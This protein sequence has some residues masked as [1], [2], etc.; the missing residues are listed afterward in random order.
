MDGAFPLAVHGPAGLLLARDAVG[1]RT[2]C[3]APKARGGF[4]YASDIKTLLTRSG[5]SGNYAAVAIVA[6]CLLALFRVFKGFERGSRSDGPGQ[7]V[8][9]AAKPG[10]DDPSVS[11]D[12]A[13][14][15]IHGIASLIRS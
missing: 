1:H 2:L 3:Y 11:C 12:K 14:G 9:R 15:A 4:A 6:V 13:N 7:V 10:G 8:G 5:N